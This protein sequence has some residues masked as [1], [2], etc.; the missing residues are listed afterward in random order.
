MEIICK[1]DCYVLAI[2][3]RFLLQYG[4]CLMDLK[5]IDHLEITG[6]LELTAVTPFS[7]GISLQ[8]LTDL[9]PS[10]QQLPYHTSIPGGLFPGRIITVSGIVPSNAKSFIINL[11]TGKDIAFHLRTL[12]DEDTVIL[13][14]QIRGIWG[15]EERSLPC[16]MP[17][18]RGRSFAMEIICKADCYV[19][20]INGRRL[21]QYCHRLMD[22][23]SI[24]HLEITEDLELTAVRV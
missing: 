17:F 13:N 15:E 11:Y 9:S 16:N 10:S 20:T 5:S 2:N 23:K 3:G 18:K 6:D 14:T 19:L 1:A 4:H 22:L 24:D 8:S 21:L 7:N 12:F